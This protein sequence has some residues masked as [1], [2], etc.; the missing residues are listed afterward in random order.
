MISRLTLPVGGVITTPLDASGS[1]RTLRADTIKKKGLKAGEKKQEM[2]G[3]AVQAK[4]MSLSDP[5][6]AKRA[7]TL[8][9]R[10]CRQPPLV[11]LTAD[12]TND[13]CMTLPAG[14]S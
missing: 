5:Q 11:P 9:L 8:T 12:K 3:E 7:G 2:R 6:S 1:G 14:N 13:G 10:W 4:P